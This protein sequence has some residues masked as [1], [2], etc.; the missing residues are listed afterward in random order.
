MGGGF[1]GSVGEWRR[2]VVSVVCWEAI[3]SAKAAWFVDWDV[4]GLRIVR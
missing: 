4:L 2:G 3:A 1:G